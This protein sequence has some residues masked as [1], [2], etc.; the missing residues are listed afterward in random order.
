MGINGESD[1]GSSS[2]KIILLVDDD[3]DTCLTFKEML[4]EQNFDVHA[5]YTA[6]CNGEV[7]AWCL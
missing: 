7:Q 4:E 5:Y 1:L 2:K 3:R 6:R